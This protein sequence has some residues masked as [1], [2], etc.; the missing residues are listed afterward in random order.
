[1]KTYGNGRVPGI[2]L[3]VE[4]DRG[5]DRVE[6]SE[7][8]LQRILIVIYLSF[9]NVNGGLGIDTDSVRHIL[10]EYYGY[11][12]YEANQAMWTALAEIGDRKY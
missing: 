8:E 2:Q 9:S 12:Q 5:R 3:S 11:E 4:Y 6:L 10:R 7:E 1:M